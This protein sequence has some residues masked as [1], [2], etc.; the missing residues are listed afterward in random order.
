MAEGTTTAAKEEKKERRRRGHLQGS[1]R[2]LIP[3]KRYEGRIRLGGKQYSVYA[4][5]AKA[6]NDKL[7]E[8]RRRHEEGLA[9]TNPNQTVAEFL[10]HWLEHVSRPSVKPQT[11]Q[12]HESA[13]RKRIIPRIGHIR[14]RQLTGQHVQALYNELL[15]SG[16]VPKRGKKQENDTAAGATKNPGLSPGS[17]VRTHAVLHKALKQAFHWRL[18]SFNPADTVSPPTVPK[19]EMQTL[20]PAQAMKL[21]EGAADATFRTLYALAVGTGLRRGE[22]LGLSW[23]D[24]DFERGILTVKRTA[25]RLKGGGVHY[26]EPKS[27]AGRR[28]IRLG[29]MVL[30]HLREHRTRQKEWKLKAG[31]AWHETDLVLTNPSGG[32][33]DAAK[34]TRTFEADRKRAGLPTVRL[35]DL[36]HTFATIALNQETPIKALQA[37]MGHSTI[38]TTI[39]TYGHLTSEL[40]ES[41]ATAMDKA[42]AKSG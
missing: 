9:I 17:V 28:S 22:L 13:I 4:K 8:L 26:G 35:H 29:D 3:K 18:I 39:D 7:L 24:I 23:S 40:Q 33:L 19:S 27:A 5:T 14:L 34:V 11:Y 42:F 6:A 20:T 10:E 32:P 30:S 36:R 2:E 37:A 15:E 25:L 16:R 41:V 1:V 12:S 31:P 21:I 38:G